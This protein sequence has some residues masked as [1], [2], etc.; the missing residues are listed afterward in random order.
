MSPNNYILLLLRY[1]KATSCSEPSE[2]PSEY[3]HMEHFP[4]TSQNA[5]QPPQF[6]HKYIFFSTFISR[7]PCPRSDKPIKPR[8][9]GPAIQ[10]ALCRV[11]LPLHA[12][13]PAPA[14]REGRAEAVRGGRAEG[15]KEGGKEG[16]RASPVSSRDRGRYKAA[17]PRGLPQSQLPEGVGVSSS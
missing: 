7:G 1:Q 15:G 11:M 9:G 2:P 8:G 3:P 10:A 16:G 6:I 14:A 17:G 4:G 5:I 12:A 13:R